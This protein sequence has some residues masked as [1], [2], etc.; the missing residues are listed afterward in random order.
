[1]PQTTQRTCFAVV[2][3]W[4]INDCTNFDV[5]TISPKTTTKT[6]YSANTEY[7]Q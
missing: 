1:M 5:T 4:L 3:N 7:E 2:V 6:P